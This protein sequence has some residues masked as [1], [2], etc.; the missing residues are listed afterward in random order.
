MGALERS[1]AHEVPEGCWLW[2]PPHQHSGRYCPQPPGGVGHGAGEK[3]LA[4][5]WSMEGFSRIRG[6]VMDTVTLILGSSQEEMMMSSESEETSYLS[7]VTICGCKC[8]TSP[9]HRS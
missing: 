8:N 5:P 9:C 7:S 2:P 1:T 4:A 3:G 6:E